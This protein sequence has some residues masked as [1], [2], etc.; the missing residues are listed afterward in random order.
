[1]GEEQ[2][3]DVPRV[4][5]GEREQ[6]HEE[7]METKAAAI[8][9]KKAGEASDK[10]SSD[11]AGQTQTR[12]QEKQENT[13]GHATGSTAPSVDS[14]AGDP[15]DCGTQK[16]QNSADSHQEQTDVHEEAEWYLVLTEDAM[17]VLQ[18]Q[19]Q[20]QQQT[21]SF[22]SREAVSPSDG[23]STCS[24][25]SSAEVAG[26]P[27]D[28]ASAGSPSGAQ[29]S[30]KSGSEGAPSGQDVIGP[31]VLSAPAHPRE[32]KQGNQGVEAG[33]IEGGTGTQPVV[34]PLTTS[35]VRVYLQHCLI[36]GYSQCWRQ[37]ME[38][39]L[40]LCNVEELKA[41]LQAS[42]E[43]ETEG[44]AAEACD[45]SNQ[46]DGQNRYRGA[47]YGGSERKRKLD[48]IAAEM[49]YVTPEGVQ[50]VFDEE[51]KTWRT[52]EEYEAL[53]SLLEDADASLTAASWKTQ[54][55][56]RKA[57]QACSPA[58]DSQDVQMASEAFVN[59]QGNHGGGEDDK[60]DET[61]KKLDGAERLKK[62]ANAE[63][64]RLYRQRQKRKKEEGRWVASRKNPNIYV[65]GLPRDCKEEELAE[66]F[67]KA[68]VFKIDPETL[69]PK[70][71]LYTDETG[72]CKGDALV[73]FVHESSVEIAIK[74]FDGASFREGGPYILQ[75]Q[76][77]EFAPKQTGTADSSAGGQTNSKE[78][79]P[80]Q[81]SSGANGGSR[82]AKRDRK[83]YLAAKYEQ[84]RLLS[85]GDAIDDGTGR[86]IIIM[87][88][89]Y[90]SEEAA[91]YEA[92]DPFYEELR[93]ELF[94]EIVQFAKPDKVTVI[95]RHVQGLA[96]VKMKTAEDAERIIEQFR[97]RFFDGRQLD[98]FFFDGKSDLKANCLPSNR[99]PASQDSASSGVKGQSSV[100]TP[101][102]LAPGG[103][104]QEGL[105]KTPVSVAAL[106]AVCGTEAPVLPATRDLEGVHSRD[107]GNAPTCP[108]DE[109]AEQERLAKFGVG[110]R[111]FFLTACQYYN[112]SLTY[113]CDWIDEQSSDEE[114]EVQTE[115]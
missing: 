88:P 73:S 54:Q 22:P 89:T 45:G 14:V 10:G 100:L 4:K 112:L 93:Q 95:P 62:E 114:F 12:K 77:A 65:S 28:S 13:V 48:N 110:R 76:R 104:E 85:W 102:M 29:T 56:R 107:G 17:A 87:K 49:K 46:G 26:T 83:K 27:A 3:T 35:A 59:A 15:K 101:K 75:V 7:E 108:G 81:S 44:L 18:Q 79:A 9:A 96:C 23:S 37:G 6:R 34:G 31:S 11:G 39:W 50:M 71:R 32:R 106:S 8:S 92:G 60:D 41:V 66:L 1:M 105:N 42:G 43:E 53:R 25:T 40:P 47:Q 84:E 80:S 61:N 30:Q 51:D 38:S 69:R 91:V 19:M 33:G 70:I 109:D 5:K 98:V 16:R 90:S 82:P 20:Q 115:S 57:G 78:G 86:R 94:D 63:K 68:G 111:I 97:G 99:R 24:F 103:F 21:Q 58:V 64:R 113:Y 52:A 2:R 72:G 74:Y 55:G 36:D 67:K